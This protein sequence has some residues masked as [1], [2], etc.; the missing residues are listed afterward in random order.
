MRLHGS[1]ERLSSD[2]FVTEQEME[3]AATGISG[4]GV[5]NVAE[6][7]RIMF[8]DAFSMIINSEPG[9]GTRIIMQIPI[10]EESLA[11]CIK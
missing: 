11:P 4:I 7:M 8:G 10:R 5:A 2:S 1:R 3:P 9:K 6:R